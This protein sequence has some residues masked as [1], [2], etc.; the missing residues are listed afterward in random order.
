[1]LNTVAP[2]VTLTLQRVFDRS[3]SLQVSMSRRM[4]LCRSLI[5]LPAEQCC[6]FID[7]TC[8]PLAE[9]RIWIV[10]S[11]SFYSRYVLRR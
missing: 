4:L 10:E 11:L 8:L 5:Y 6:I 3:L 9:F 2:N 1:M 7:F